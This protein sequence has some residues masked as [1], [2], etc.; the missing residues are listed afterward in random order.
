DVT[1]GKPRTAETK[2]AFYGRLVEL[3]AESPGIRPEDVMTVVT[4]TAREDWSFG[5]G[6]AQMTEAQQ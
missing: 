6:R 4:T 3:L 1:I 2:K 5:N